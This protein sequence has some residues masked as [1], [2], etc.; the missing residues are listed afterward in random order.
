MKQSRLRFQKGDW[1][2]VVLVCAMV[3]T[4]AFWLPELRSGGSFAQIWQDGIL[5]RQVPLSVD[6]TFQIFG[7]YTNT[8]T[9]SD[10][11]IAVTHSDC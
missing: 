11:K 5:I 10:G 1:V 8:V 3:L 9:V 7:A 2:A 6:Q 4:S